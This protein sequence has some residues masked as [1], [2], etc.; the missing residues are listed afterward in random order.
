[1]KALHNIQIGT[2]FTGNVDK[3]EYEVVGLDRGRF[4]GVSVVVVRNLKT[5]RQSA[6]GMEALKRYDI[7]ITDRG[8][9][10]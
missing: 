3:G 6:I 4:G 10:E 5:G 7:T 9:T 2:R 1:M 8:P